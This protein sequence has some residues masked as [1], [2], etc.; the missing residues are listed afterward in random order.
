MLRISQRSRITCKA[1]KQLRARLKAFFRVLSMMKGPEPD[2]HK[3][4]EVTLRSKPAKDAKGGALN[5]G[6]DRPPGS[7]RT[8]EI[9]FMKDLE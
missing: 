9:D 6:R 7:P 2:G 8:G 4:Q 5:D 1:D 3:K